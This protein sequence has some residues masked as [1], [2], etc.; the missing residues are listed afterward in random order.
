MFYLGPDGWNYYSSDKKTWVNTG[1]KSFGQH[2]LQVASTDADSNWGQEELKWPPDA[3][4]PFSGTKILCVGRNYR[5]HAAELGNDVPTRP[6]WF[7]KPPSSIIGEGGT[8]VL[9]SDAGRIDYEGE[10]ALII[11]KR[12]C[13]V[14]PGEACDCIGGVTACLDMTARELQKSDGQWTRAK[15]F[16]TFLPL[17]SLVAPFSQEWAA[18]GIEVKKNGQIVQKS[19]FSAMVFGFAE[20][21]ADISACMTLEPGDLILTGTP[22]GIGPVIDGDR[23][24]V[25]I[26]G[27]AT[28]NLRVSCA[29][30]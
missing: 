24:E 7:S 6:L 25:I 1:I 4:P 27:P 23:L 29:G 26:N 16:D 18:G 21:I 9:P 12:A 11:S 14:S 8:V 22:E 10:L 20:L 2:F 19:D 30:N 13:K 15:G 17:A 3:L 5:K 28:L